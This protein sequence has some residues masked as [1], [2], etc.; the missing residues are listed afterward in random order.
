MR[1]FIYLCVGLLGLLSISTTA[2]AARAKSSVK[3]PHQVVKVKPFTSL[4]IAGGVDVVLRKAAKGS[5][6]ELVGAG[7]HKIAVRVRKGTLSISAPKWRSRTRLP[8]ITVWM[9]QPLQ[10]LNVS[11]IA[12]ITAHQLNT[13]KLSVWSKSSGDVQLSGN[14]GLTQLLQSGGGVVHILGIRGD[15]LSVNLSKQATANLSGRVGQL[16]ARLRDLSTLKASGLRAGTIFVSTKGNSVA[17][18]SPVSNLRAF[19]RNQSQ[20]FYYRSP[21]NATENATGSANIM[22]MGWRR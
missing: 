19:A 8:Q 17:K 15:E 10:N 2:F 11:G 13:K 14:I 5:V 1:R 18:V 16:N 20:V 21:S 22:Q 4:S 6:V 9:K 7:I 3:L 12:N